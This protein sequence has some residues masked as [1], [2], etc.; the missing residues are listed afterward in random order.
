[1]IDF[2]FWPTPNG[3][4]AAIMLAELDV[5]YSV[6]PINITA[7]AQFAPEY[8]EIN[9]NSKVPAIVDHDGP[10]RQRLPIFES[11]AILIYLAEKY[12]KFLSDDPVSRSET[13]QWLFFQNAAVGPMLGQA[14]HFMVYASEQ[15]PY[16]IERYGREAA[17]LYD[18]LERRLGEREYLAGD[19]SIAD[20]ST[21]PWI[22]TRKLHRRDL[23]DY[24]NITR[25]YEAIKQRPGVRKGIDTLKD[26]KEWEAKP[27]SDEWKN[28]FGKGKS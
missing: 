9:P 11:G 16:A 5:E 22:R 7:G 23:A 13:L 14:H 28:M 3:Y 21:F 17:R 1:M 27:G 15:I 8:V 6:V 12:G 18:I 20:I 2:Y 10:H 19:Y 26:K 25:W 24:P 4:K